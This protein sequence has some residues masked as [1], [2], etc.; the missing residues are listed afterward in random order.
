MI[1]KFYEYYKEKN[2]P[3]IFCDVD[4]CLI[5]F[6]GKTDHR[7]FSEVDKWSK[8]AMIN[9][10]KIIEE[11]GAEIIISS[12]YRKTKT[13]EEIQKA[14]EKAGFKYKIKE[15]LPHHNLDRAS[16]IN[17]FL[18][19][20]KDTN[21]IIIDDHK[22]KIPEFFPKHVFIKIKTTIG[23]TYNDA[24]KAIKSLNN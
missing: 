9:L 10:N 6:E 16:A 12:T 19:N 1:K 23:I 7:Y 3:I 17:L 13:K 11:T 8:N 2:N 22:H 21:F 18:K 20:K 5:P 24:K 14:F 4:G 15:L